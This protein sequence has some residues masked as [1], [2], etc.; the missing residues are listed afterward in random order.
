MSYTGNT[1]KFENVV[2]T[3]P[4]DN[5]I[6]ALDIDWVLGDTYHKTISAASTFTFTNDVNGKSIVVAIT[7]SDTSDHDMTWPAGVLADLNYTGT[8]IA[9]TT[10]LFTFVK[11]NGTVYVAEIKEIA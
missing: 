10:T 2:E 1:P 6:P 7:N 5:A 3:A 9:G 8:V 11:I 4:L